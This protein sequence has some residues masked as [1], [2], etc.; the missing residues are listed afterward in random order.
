MTDTTLPLAFSTL[1]FLSFFL[2]LPSKATDIK[3][4]HTEYKSG[5]DRKAARA[6]VIT[7]LNT[8]KTHVI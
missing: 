6:V 4:V 2:Y 1:V 3:N 7:A 8:S 5:Q